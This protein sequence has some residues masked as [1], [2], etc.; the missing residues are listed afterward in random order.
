MSHF[1]YLLWPREFVKHNEATYKIGKTTRN[2]HKRLSEYAKGSEL[3]LVVKVDDCHTMEITLIKL[4]DIRF[5]KRTEYGNEYYS[6]DVERMRYE[7]FMAI[8]NDSMLKQCLKQ[9]DIVTKNIETLNNE[10]EQNRQST[11]KLLKEMIPLTD[12]SIDHLDDESNGDLKEQTDIEDVESIKELNTVEK[13]HSI[14]VNIHI[15]K[16]IKRTE[17][18]P[19]KT[20]K[21]FYKFIYDTRPDWYLERKTVDIDIIA[22]AYRE[23]FE[24]KVITSA[25]VSRILK[26]LFMSSVRSNGVTKKR[27]VDFKTL[28][29]L[30]V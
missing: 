21:S 20:L 26:N 22:D 17:S 9:K 19:M 25:N 29:K 13:N 15:N 1:I 28:Q 12:I 3:I 23:Y 27:L 24:N 8:I 18:V 11:P 6:G 10:S 14:N 30:F 7:I 5:V 16:L 4:F 2:P